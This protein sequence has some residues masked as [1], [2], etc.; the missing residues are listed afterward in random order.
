MNERQIKTLI[1]LSNVPGVG[2]GT[3]NKAYGFMMDSEGSSTSITNA[4]EL[5]AWVKK[6]STRNAI[7]ACSFLLEN[8]DA[9][10]EEA[11]R[12]HEEILKQNVLILEGHDERFPES[13]KQ[14][15][16]PFIFVMGDPKILNENSLGLVGTR[17]PSAMGGS[18][19]RS[20]VKM[21]HGTG[22]HT[23]SG[24]AMGIDTV[25]QQSSLD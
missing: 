19:T 25:A 20:I 17:K 13:L 21:L 5:A 2:Q 22:I 9:L 23:V 11:N 7:K 6:S 12:T 8:W 15:G 4:Q 1:A 24:L 18:I 16:I 14:I 10:T 3:I